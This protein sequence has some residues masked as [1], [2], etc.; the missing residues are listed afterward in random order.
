M[1]D[2]TNIKPKILGLSRCEIG[3]KG[4]KFLVDGRTDWGQLEELY[5]SHNKVKDKGIEALVKLE[6]PH[7]QILKINDNIV[8]DK[9]LKYLSKCHWPCLHTLDLSQNSLTQHSPQNLTLAHLPNL[10]SINLCT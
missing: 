10:K 4:L 5:L 8:T 6:C 3:E 7:L 2:F 9:G 1:S